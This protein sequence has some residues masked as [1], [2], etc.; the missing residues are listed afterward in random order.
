MENFMKI[1]KKA[2]YVSILYSKI[3]ALLGV[4][5]VLNPTGAFHLVSWTLGILFIIIGIYKVISYFITKKEGILYNYNLIYGLTAIII[6]IISIIYMNIIGS[7]FRIII[8]IW[9]IYTSFLSINSTL[10]L[11]AVG[12]KSW[13]YSLI[14]SIIM[15]IC[16][17]YIIVSS[18]AIIV[19]VGII[20]IICSIM[21][22]IE[23][24]V[25]IKNLN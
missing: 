11:K 7:M 12:N 13:I 10:Q 14:L 18:G 17:L 25:L 22:I 2:Q 16:G 3:F 24:I 8:G 4:I 5:L 20:M 19:A 15:F 23:D 9:I 21:N 6:G 1:F